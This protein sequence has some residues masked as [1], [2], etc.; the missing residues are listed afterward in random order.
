MAD[1]LLTGGKIATMDPARPFVEALAV[2]DGKVLET[3]SAREL[4]QRYG[5]A[6]E[7]IDL[8]GRTVVPGLNDSHAHMIREGLNFA[9]ELRWDGVPSLHD[10]LQMLRAQ[11]RRTP[12]GQWIRVVGGWSPFQFEEQRLPTLEEINEVA[13]DHPVFVLY[14]Y[15]RAWL[16]RAALQALAYTEHTFDNFPAGEIQRDEKGRPTGLLLARPNAL[17]LYASLDRG[18]KLAYDEQVVSTLHYQRELNRL[19]LTSTLDCG[20][21]FQNYPEDYGPLARLHGERRLTV[22]IGMQLFAQKPGRELED[23]RRW[24]EMTAPDRGDAFLKVNGAG[25]MLAATAYDFEDFLFPRPEM[26]P[27][28]E[29]ELMAVLDYLVARRWPFRFHCTYEESALRILD[30][31]EEIDRRYSLQGLNWIFDHGE[32]ISERTMERIARMGGGIAVQNRIAFQAPYFAARYGE[33][34][35]K[36]TPPVRKMLQMG[37]PVAAGTDCTRVSS[38]NPWLS[39]HWLVS[40]RALGGQ[41]IYDEDNRL[42]RTEA[43]RLWTE[44]G[45]WFSREEGVKGALVPGQLA[46]LAV[47]SEDYFEM[48]ENRI[49]DLFSVLTLVGGDVVHAEAEF[50]ALAPPAP[51]PLVEWSPVNRFGG[52]GAP[53]FYGREV[54]LYSSS[55]GATDGAARQAERGDGAP[56][57]SPPDNASAVPGETMP[58]R[59]VPGS[60]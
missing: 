47:L 9:L 18:P 53:L 1:T 24:H 21:G 39:V 51:P 38:Y 30:V 28:M 5:D 4:A 49:S 43:L 55:D 31:L 42:S 41:V 8:R 2:R 7:T 58:A 22:R 59:A 12:P 34:A 20:G 32:T 44:A 35:L 26:V 56:A 27:Q 6:A 57:S 19:G 16:N 11:A 37:L 40:G 13:P 14:V 60:E 45:A 46:D 3:G 33:A 25:E 10:A 29:Q 54:P 48:E 50:A 23:F 17:I 15:D 52:Y 36:Q